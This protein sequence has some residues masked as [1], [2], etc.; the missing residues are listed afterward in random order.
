MISMSLSVGS[1]HRLLSFKHDHSLHRIWTEVTVLEENENYIVVANRRTKVVEANGRYWYTKEPS[2][3]FFFKDHW[4]NVIGIIKDTG[5]CFYCNIS[6]PVLYDD[7]AIKYID[8]DLDIKVE[9][10]YSYRVLDWKEY[11]KHRHM[12]NYPDEL[13]KILEMEL[14][15]LK[16]RIENHDEPFRHETIRFNYDKYLHIGDNDDVERSKN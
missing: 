4:Y 13:C 10:D 14:K 2:V 8:Y 3:S 7:E 1:V 16:N 9:T 11:R 5:I 15:H 6:S 12:M